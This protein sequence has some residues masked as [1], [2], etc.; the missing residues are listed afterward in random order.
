MPEP[1][2]EMTGVC[3][4]FGGN[5]VLSDVSL[6]LAAHEVH[7][8]VG[9]NGA[10]KSTLMK[11]LNGVY[12]MDAGR[13]VMAGQE[14]RIGS[15]YDARKAGISMIF[16]EQILAND[17]TVA[18][19]IFLGIEPTGRHG[20]LDNRT[21]NKRAQEVLERHNFPLLATASVGRLTRAE[22]QLVEIAR[23]L[24]TT[25]RVI[26]MDEPTAVLSQKESEELFRI[27]AELKA[28][29]LAVVYI[30]HRM[31]EL[32]R[33]ADRATILRDGKRVFTG[34]RDSIDAAGIIRY[35]V[36]RDIHEL[37]PKLPAPGTEA[38]LEVRGL[39]RGAEYRNISFE[40]RKGEI[41][42]LAGLVGAGRTA[43]ARGIFGLDPAAEGS[44]IVNGKPV[45]FRTTGDAISAGLGYLTEDRK[46]VGILPDLPVTHNISIAAL[47]TMNSGPIL[48]LS[49]ESRRCSELVK[50]L[51][52]R[53]RSQTMPIGRLSGGNQQKALLAR[54]LFAGSSILM[55]DEPTQGVDLGTR[56][57]IYL[58]MKE[59]IAGGGSILMIS[60]DLTELM[61][62]SHRIG[63]MRRGELVA[64]LSAQDATQEEVMR[65]AA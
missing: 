5:C 64:M 36:G 43:V 58:L 16:Q 2:L 48:N 13:I 29:G 40:L 27:I 10:G 33:I 54:W 44:L 35:M 37:Y 49:E 46:A 12:T 38:V 4:S 24:A 26:V 11:I 18:E 65:H 53:A 39:T 56:A 15:P 14:I 55:L 6:S 59:I 32:T 31:E 17:L 21:L 61:G 30:S 19:N 50:K 25:A 22:K 42:G 41:L 20:L 57:E 3:K 60:S 51:N 28:K 1:L 8:L 34:D 23:A 63:V 7:A 9:E 52:V 47:D 62:M 45:R